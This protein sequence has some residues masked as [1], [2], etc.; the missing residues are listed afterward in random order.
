MGRRPVGAL[1]REVLAALWQQEGAATPR[2]V[3]EALA[4]KL[5]YTTVMTILTR[6]WRKGV[7]ERSRHGRA[8]R[9]RPLKTEAELAAARMQAALGPEPDRRRVLS[10]FVDGLSARDE[11]TLRAI[12][13]DEQ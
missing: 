4:E 12:L 13:E 5:A 8:F 2:Q 7:V 6:L 9:Y 10:H 3:Q 1:E 11:R